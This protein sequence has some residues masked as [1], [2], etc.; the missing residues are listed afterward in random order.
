MLSNSSVNYKYNSPKDYNTQFSQV[1]SNVPMQA[2]LD[3]QKVKQTVDNSYIANRVKAS[4]DTNPLV[5]T[6]FI[7]A[8]W[9][10]LSRAMDRFGKKC[11]GKYED[12]VLGKLGNFGDKVQTKFSSNILAK[13]TKKVSNALSDGLNW[14]TNKSKIV[15]AIRNTPAQAEWKLAKAPIAGLKGFLAMDIE[16]LFGYFM[17][18]ISNVQQ[19]EQFGYSQDKIDKFAQTLKSL[20]SNARKVELAKEELR[21][22]GVKDSSIDKIYNSKKGIGGLRTYAEHLKARKLGFRNLAEYTE[23]S[24]DPL[25]NIDKVYNALLK[26]DD[27]MCASYGRKYGK[28]GKIC[29][30]LF[31]RKVTIPELRNKMIATLG[32][33][34]K[35]KLG[36]FLP[37][38]LGYFLEGT[39]NRFAGGKIA[40]LIQASIFGDMLANILIAPKG[41]KFK[42]FAERF[43][44]DFAYFLAMP[45]AGAL[46]FK[47]AGMKYIG[48]DKAGVEAYRNSLKAFNE[49]AK[50]CVFAN[51]AEYNVEKKF[52]KDMLKGNV[53][54][55]ITRLFKKIGM[56][57][58]IGNESIAAYR[59]PAGMNLNLLRKIPNFLKNLAGVPLRVIIPTGVLIPIIVKFC[60]KTENKIFGKPTKSVLDEEPKEDSQLNETQNKIQVDSSSGNTEVSI[61][62]SPTNLI[63]MHQ[64]NLKYTPSQ[65]R[66]TSN[67]VVNNNTTIINKT[68]EPD[69]NAVLEP[70]RTYI[71]SPVGVQVKGEDQS[72]ALAAL[73]RSDIAE[74][75]AMETLAMKW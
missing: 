35:T 20:D 34:N 43:V 53:K 25:K 70:L 66:V 2:T 68:S 52:L 39:T 26:A 65:D 42:T 46:L 54:N 21:A 1:N 48:L 29:A 73:S 31:G 19:L 27:K 22:L 75:K 32:K 74:K 50:N 59:S 57:L 9:Y 12:T 55:P 60:T 6:S 24:K 16:Q 5:T 72:A 67:N 30:H 13:G 28:F 41:E 10:G 23:V 49:K 7:L 3:S 63:N 37:K 45:I 17:E 47:V 38:A 11:E 58:N 69:D 33:G 36:N 62:Q 15:Y 4:E 8:S 71:P 14:L 64:N 51:K 44:N 56:L 40:V 18:P 61:P